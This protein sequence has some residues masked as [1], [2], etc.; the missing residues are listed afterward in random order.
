MKAAWSGHNH[1]EAYADYW[2]LDE[3][4]WHGWQESLQE[5]KRYIFPPIWAFARINPIE[6]FTML[7]KQMFDYS[8]Y[9]HAFIAMH[10]SMLG[11]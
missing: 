1:I 5:R 7:W 10:C 3:T 2:S 11:Q 6:A 9:G 8:V 4:Q